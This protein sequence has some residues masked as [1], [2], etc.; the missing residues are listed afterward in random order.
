MTNV[1]YRYC[2]NKKNCI[3]RVNLITYFSFLL[4]TAYAKNNKTNSWYHFDDSTV[5]SCTEDQV[6]VSIINI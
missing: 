1:L 6:V 2:Q 3:K 4:D 5:T